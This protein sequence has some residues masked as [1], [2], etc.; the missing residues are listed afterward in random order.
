M[1]PTIN[2]CADAALLLHPVFSPVTL[3][4]FDLLL[5][6]KEKEAEQIKRL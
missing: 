1:C 5:D 6:L 4:R 3:W 2:V